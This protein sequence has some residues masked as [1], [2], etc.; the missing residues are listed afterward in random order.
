MVKHSI[1]H[2]KNKTLSRF[3]KSTLLRKD[4][5]NR[6]SSLIYIKVVEYILRRRGKERESEIHRLSGV[7]FLSSEGS[8]TGGLPGLPRAIWYLC[9]WTPPRALFNFVVALS[10]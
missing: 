9:P 8:P 10:G 7:S 1:V 2:P 4:V 5:H 3:S 6:T